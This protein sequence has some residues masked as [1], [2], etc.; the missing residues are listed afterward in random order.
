MAPEQ[1][2]KVLYVVTRAYANQYGDELQP[3]EEVVLLAS[4][5]AQ[6]ADPSLPKN[7]TKQQMIFR[8]ITLELADG[9]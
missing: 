2:A 1:I 4:V 3:D 5:R 9:V 8:Q 7:P 6:L